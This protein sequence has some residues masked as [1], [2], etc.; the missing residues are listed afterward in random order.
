MESTK[1]IVFRKPIT[2]GQDEGRK[3]YESLQLR[4][5]TAAEYEAAE[6]LSLEYGM[7][8]PLIAGVS[9]VPLDVVDQMFE[10]QINEA[11]DF[12]GSFGANLVSPKKAS[13][14]ELKISLVAPVKL[15]EDDSALNVSTL[16][17]CEPTNLQRRKSREAGGP[18]AQAIELI[19]LNAHIPKASVRAM[20]ARDFLA[21]TGY[22]NGFQLRRRTDRGG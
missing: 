11:E 15:T 5:P 10:S 21:A 1:T 13:A 6:K 4:E 17:L 22:F 14:N 3:T 7:A 12:L 18:V 2:V 16:T 19:S 8:A 9:G 20:C